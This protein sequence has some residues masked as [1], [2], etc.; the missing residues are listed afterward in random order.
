MSKCLLTRFRAICLA[1]AGP[2]SSGASDIILLA[3]S[4]HTDRRKP[5]GKKLA[6]SHSKVW[7]FC[8]DDIYQEFFK[9]CPD[10]KGVKIFSVPDRESI[11]EQRYYFQKPISLGVNEEFRHHLGSVC[12]TIW[13]P[14]EKEN[15]CPLV[16][17]YFGFVWR[18]TVVQVFST[19]QLNSLSFEI[20]TSSRGMTP[21][22]I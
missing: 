21:T 8:L 4:F 6:L 3:K 9:Q 20:G 14:S 15:T 19:S 7:F 22:I 18:R 17:C 11:I 1:K 5:W 2:E 16:L 10:T 12:Q 13:L